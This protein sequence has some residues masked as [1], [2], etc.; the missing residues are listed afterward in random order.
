MLNYT[1]FGTIEEPKEPERVTNRIK[2]MQEMYGYTEGQTCKTCK[3]L[4]KHRYHDHTYHKCLQ[5]KLSHSSATDVRLKN[6]ACGR[7][8]MA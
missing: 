5:W 7:W 1:I 4:L 3:H 6:K 2:T 8:E